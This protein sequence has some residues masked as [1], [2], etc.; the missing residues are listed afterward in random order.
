MQSSETAQESLDEIEITLKVRFD[1]IDKAILEIFNRSPTRT[2][3]VHQ[4][5]VILDYRGMNIN[6]GKLARRLSQFSDLSLISKTK[7]S[8]VFSY[9]L[10]D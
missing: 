10:L 8:K 6:Y 3:R 4:I 7:S 9:K 1:E 2:F 5:K